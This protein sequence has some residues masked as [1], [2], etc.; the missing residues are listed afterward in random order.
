MTRPNYIVFYVKGDGNPATFAQK[1]LNDAL[2]ECLWNTQAHG[3]QGWCICEM[4]YS[5]LQSPDGIKEGLAI[6]VCQSPSWHRLI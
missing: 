5:E 4:E 1:N 3:W 6:P 2:R